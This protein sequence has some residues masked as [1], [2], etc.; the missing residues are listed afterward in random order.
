MTLTITLPSELEQ[1]LREAAAQSG[2]DAES[3]AL[4]L[5]VSHLNPNR[6]EQKADQPL[7][8]EEWIREFEAYIDSHDP[9]R[10]P[11][12]LEAFERQSFYR[13]R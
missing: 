10:P 7:S 13:D 2:K 3:Y 12:P 6:E 5:L 1:R 8:P 9:M 11:L 4:D